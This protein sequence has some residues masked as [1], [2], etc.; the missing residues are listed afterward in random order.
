MDLSSSQQPW[1]PGTARATMLPDIENE[2]AVAVRSAIKRRVC[3]LFTSG[4][5]GP[6]DDDLTLAA[7]A[8]EAG[9]ALELNVTAREMVK[10]RY[11][12]FS[13]QGGLNPFREKMAWLPANAHPFTIRWVPPPVSC[14][15]REQQQSF[16]CPVCRRNLRRSSPTP[17]PVSSPQPLA[18]AVSSNER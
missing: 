7:I 18:R 4:G 5:F 8:K 17:W 3:V 13:A 6:T 11:D 15:S 9:V 1:W 16:V 2:I 12:D 14:C 10:E